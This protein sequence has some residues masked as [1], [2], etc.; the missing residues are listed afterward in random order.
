MPRVISLTLVRFGSV[1]FGSPFTFTGELLDANDSL[2]LRARYYSPALGVFTAMDP[3]ENLNQYQYVG[4]N[5][6]NL[7]DPSGMI[8]EL[9]G[10]WDPCWRQQE[11]ECRPECCSLVV[12]L[13]L[14]WNPLIKSGKLCCECPSSETPIPTIVPTLGAVTSTPGATA[15]QT[16]TATPTAT[17]TVTATPTATPGTC[18]SD[19]LFGCYPGTTTPIQAARIP[20]IHP[21]PA[22]D[23]VP[24]NSGASAANLNWEANFP[25]AL[26]TVHAVAGGTVITNLHGYND[27]NYRVRTDQTIEV[28]GKTYNVCYEYLHLEPIP[29]SPAYGSIISAGDPLGAI[30][31]YQVDM[32]LEYDANLGPS[33]V[34]IA[35]WPCDPNDAQMSPAAGQFRL[36][37]VSELRFIGGTS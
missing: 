32:G 19:S 29:G 37:P 6:I 24:E 31:P 22:A 35:I 15:T 4:G 1:C 11:K 14:V 20:H 5:V 18:P 33:H 34:H 30:E 16:A 27:G 8:G 10:M 2:Y 7:V 36:D 28:G 13:A 25:Q 21:L 26:R 17:T 9:L 12:K 3:V 23:F